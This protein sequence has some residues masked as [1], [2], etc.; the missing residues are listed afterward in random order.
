MYF[1]DF[2]LTNQAKTL[3]GHEKVVTRKG[4]TALKTPKGTDAFD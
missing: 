2:D 3:H 1:T 4:K